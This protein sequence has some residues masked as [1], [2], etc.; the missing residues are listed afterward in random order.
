MGDEV[1]RWKREPTPDSMN[2]AVLIRVLTVPKRIGV[3]HRHESLRQSARFRHRIRAMPRGQSEEAVEWLSRPMAMHRMLQMHAIRPTAHADRVAED[4][5]PT[6]SGVW[7]RSVRR[8]KWSDDDGYG[9]LSEANTCDG[10]WARWMDDGP[11]RCRSRGL[12]LWEPSEVWV[13][14]TLIPATPSPV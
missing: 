11:V 3:M 13:V 7:L 2:G 8:S 4:P 1:G 14:V 6:G 9:R 5:P 10:A 12:A